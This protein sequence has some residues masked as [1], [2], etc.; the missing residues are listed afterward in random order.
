MESMPP[1]TPFAWR[2]AG[3]GFCPRVPVERECHAPDWRSSSEPAG[4]VL[5]RPWTWLP[6]T[7]AVCQ[8]PLALP[9]TF[10]KFPRDYLLHLSSS[11]DTSP[12][13]PSPHSGHFL[14]HSFPLWQWLRLHLPL[15][16]FSLPLSTESQ[17]HRPHARGSI[18]PW[19]LQ[20]H[21]PPLL[22]S[23]AKSDSPQGN[24]TVVWLDSDTK[25]TPIPSRDKVFSLKPKGNI[26]GLSKHSASH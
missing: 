13:F 2:F 4:C 9:S 23:R 11:K 8:G 19:S 24:T 25:N 16:L 15:L 21:G 26:L 6:V 7:T 3:S 20:V 5:Q 14:F 22:L 17:P 18:A 1:I 12:S 10:T